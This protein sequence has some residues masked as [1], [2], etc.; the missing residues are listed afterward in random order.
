MMPLSHFKRSINEMKFKMAD[1]VG[2]LI[3]QYNNFMD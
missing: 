2:E 1:K 3:D